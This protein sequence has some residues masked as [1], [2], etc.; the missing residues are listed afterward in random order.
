MPHQESGTKGVVVC[1]QCDF[2][3]DAMDEKN[4]KVHTT[5]KT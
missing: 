5:I 3:I 4:N 1:I 2:P